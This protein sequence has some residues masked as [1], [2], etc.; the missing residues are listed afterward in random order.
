M[1]VLVIKIDS[2]KLN[3]VNIYNPSGDKI[4]EQWENLLDN[5]SKPYI[6]VGDLN[7]HDSLWGCR[8]N[9]QNCKFIIKTLEDNNLVILNDDSPTRLNLPG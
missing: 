6:I 8:K 4:K 3:T 7:T 9:D 2:L 1:Q 5:L